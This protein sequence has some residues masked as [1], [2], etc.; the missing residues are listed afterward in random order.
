[1]GTYQTGFPKDAEV[2]GGVGLF[3]AAGAVDLTDA[4]RSLAEALQDAQAGRV[5]EGGEQ[6]GHAVQLALIDLAH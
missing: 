3:E 1:M 4:A 2:L 5:R 6:G